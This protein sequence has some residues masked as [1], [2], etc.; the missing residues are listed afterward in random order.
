MFAILMSGVLL[1]AAGPCEDSARG[2][3]AVCLRGSMTKA[4]AAKIEV[5]AF[6]AFARQDCATEVAVFR[7]ALAAYDM[8]AGWARKKADTD[9][10]QQIRDSLEDWTGRYKDQAAAAK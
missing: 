3:F 4:A 5:P 9:A 2:K 7:A 10:D 8:K 6:A 1:V